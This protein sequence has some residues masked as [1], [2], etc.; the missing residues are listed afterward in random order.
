M[1]KSTIK[2]KNFPQ[3]TSCNPPTAL[4]RALAPVFHKYDRKHSHITVIQKIRRHKRR[5]WKVSE[6]W[7]RQNPAEPYTRWIQ[8]KENIL[9]EM[10][11]LLLLFSFFLSSFH[12]WGKNIQPLSFWTWL[13]LLSIYLQRTQVHCS[14]KLNKTLLCTYLISL[15]SHLLMDT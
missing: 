14:L 11:P 12:L 5:D 10:Q 15:F 7:K 13:I 2:K 6:T 8:W 1:R 9:A 3:F 4:K